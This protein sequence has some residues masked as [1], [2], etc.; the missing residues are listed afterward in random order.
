MKKTTPL[1]HSERVDAD[2]CPA[3]NRHRVEEEH[4]WERQAFWQKWGTIF[5]FFAVGAAAVYACFAYQQVT[6]MRKAVGEQTKATGAAVR[7]AKA[8]EE[9]STIAAR[10]I[11]LSVRQF[12]AT[13]APY[14][15]FTA[16]PPHKIVE[17]VA[18]KNNPAY[19]PFFDP[20]WIDVI[21]NYKNI[22]LTVAEKQ[23][24]QAR[25]VVTW[26]GHAYTLS[27]GKLTPNDFDWNGRDIP[28]GQH[29]MAR[30]A[31]WLPQYRAI[32]Q[33]RAALTVVVR[34]EYADAVR[35]HCVALEANYLG[36]RCGFDVVR[37]GYISSF[38][39]SS[40]AEF[41]WSPPQLP[42][43]WQHKKDKK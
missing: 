33:G 41:T 28:P 25:A 29:A 31:I 1:S 14:I 8:A 2:I 13:Q 5:T 12:E 32:Q 17:F 18:N 40:G 37:N 16:D 10:S 39:T 42:K 4:Y 3:C 19:D 24:A 21:V 43:C 38:C 11:A 23:F 22:G 30:T 15:I 36:P 35:T 26:P 27:F 7:S 34:I 6:E 20:H 9:A